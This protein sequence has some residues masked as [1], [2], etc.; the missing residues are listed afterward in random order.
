MVK[1]DL[2]SGGPSCRV[3]TVERSLGG[4]KK[5]MTSLLPVWYG[6]ADTNMVSA[7]ELDVLLT[8]AI[9]IVMD[10]LQI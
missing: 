6:A 5:R 3:F 10:P 1:L 9:L 7:T 8:V 4:P 2:E